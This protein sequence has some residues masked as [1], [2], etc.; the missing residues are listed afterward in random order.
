MIIANLSSL[1]TAPEKKKAA[2]LMF[3][4]P[5]LRHTIFKNIHSV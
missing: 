4:D 1:M 3:L 2:N 5:F